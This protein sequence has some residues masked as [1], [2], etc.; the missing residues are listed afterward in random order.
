MQ[1]IINFIIKIF[2]GNIPLSVIM[3][4]IIPVIEIRGAI[5]LGA[6]MGLSVMQSYGYSL[7]GSFLCSVLLLLTV[8]LLLKLLEKTK[9][10]QK[11]LNI[12]M[13]KIKKLEN[14]KFNIYFALLTFVAI[15]VPL[16]GVFTGCLLA[17]VFKLNFF[18]SLIA[19]NV[20]NVIAGAI[21]SL[22]T[23]FLGAYSIYI[24][25]FF[26]IMLVVIGVVYL[27]K[28]AKK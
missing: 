22:I 11:F 8:P 19:I 21:I 18:K 3:F 14:A 6:N 24:T 27:T 25:L 20:G 28:F 15:P 9:F 26:M 23:K 16:T 7:I 13:P 1:N 10:Y 5:P 17:C 2:N 4:S 12:I